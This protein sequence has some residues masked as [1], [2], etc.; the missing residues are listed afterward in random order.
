MSANFAT[1]Q[2]SQVL[3][4]KDGGETHARQALEILCSAYWY[5]LY[6]YVRHQGYDPEEARD[7]TQGYFAEL[8]DKEFLKERSRPPST[9]CVDGTDSVYAPR[10]PIPWPILPMSTTRCAT[11][12][13]SCGGSSCIGRG[14]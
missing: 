6:A 5:P 10:S 13:R 1:T 11:C 3:A 8:L 14:S 7:L 4:A 12:W 2:W 9:D